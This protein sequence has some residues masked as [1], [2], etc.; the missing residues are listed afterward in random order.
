MQVS[1][2][3]VNGPKSYKVVF[4]DSSLKRKQLSLFCLLWLSSACADHIGYI[5][6]LCSMIKLLHELKNSR[7]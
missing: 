6:N 4:R 5:T 2:Y 1:R 3:I 7:C